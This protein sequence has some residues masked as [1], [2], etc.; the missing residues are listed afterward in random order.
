MATC[1]RIQNRET[2]RDIS[3]MYVTLMSLRLKG[4]ETLKWRCVCR[5]PCEKV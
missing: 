2:K 5:P 4:E 1:L 3:S